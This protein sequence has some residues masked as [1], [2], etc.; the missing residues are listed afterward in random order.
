MHI[1][2]ALMTAAIAT[3]AACIGQPA[4]ATR[5]ILDQ[6]TGNTLVVA[7]KPLVFARERADVAAHARGYVMLSAV[8]V[9]ESGKY[10]EYFLLH[11]WSTVDRRMLPTPDRSAGDLRILAD[12]RTIDL[13]PLESVPAD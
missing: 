9:N 2:V 13:L 5:E 11:R 10:R 12:E 6:Q 3:L 8:A 4:T 1:R 7:A